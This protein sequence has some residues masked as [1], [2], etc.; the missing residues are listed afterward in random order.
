MKII[1]C[2]EEK[3][4]KDFL[5][6]IIDLWCS[7]KF[8]PNNDQHISWLNRKIHASF[9]DFGFALCAYTDSDEPIGYILYKHDTGMEGVSFSG[10]N[11]HIIQFGLFEEYRNKGIG[12]KLLNEACKNIKDNNGECL[13][14]D[15][16]TKN[17]DSMIYYIKRGFIPV[18]YYIGENGING[19]GQIYLYKI[20]T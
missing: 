8:I 14:T 5:T 9:V 16:Y 19:F 7:D 1:H 12:T 4:K 17:D 18:A 11:A 3:F 20:L 2:D 15:T 6:M 13:Y 10:K